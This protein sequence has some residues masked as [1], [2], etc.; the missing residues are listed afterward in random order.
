V[1]LISTTE[2]DRI[3]QCVVGKKAW[4]TRFTREGFLFIEF[5][6]A[7]QAAGGINEVVHGQWSFWIYCAKWHLTKCERR[8]VDAATEPY[9]GQ[10][11]VEEVN[12]LTLEAIAYSESTATLIM[13]FNCNI[14]LYAAAAR[15]A[16]EDDD[17]WMLFLPDDC[18]L[19]A[20]GNGTFTLEQE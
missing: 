6:E 8:C 15:D 4:G 11:E 7:A 13:Q 2:V 9:L 20:E 12:G 16:G 5:G 10:R 1:A 3:V 18:V 17:Q 19:T 14:I